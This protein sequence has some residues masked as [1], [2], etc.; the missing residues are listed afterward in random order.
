[1]T[2]KTHRTSNKQRHVEIPGTLELHYNSVGL[3]FLT[4]NVIVDSISKSVAMLQSTSEYIQRDK[5][6]TEVFE[7]CLETS[8]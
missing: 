1:M 3:L 8:S 2:I 5:L 6:P 4:I 7:L